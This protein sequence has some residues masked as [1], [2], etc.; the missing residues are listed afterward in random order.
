[1]KGLGEGFL[2][3]SFDVLAKQTFQDFDVVI[4]DHSLDDGIENLCK[5][6]AD[7]LT[8]HYYRNAEH[9]G[10]SS[11]N[12][13][14]AIRQAR[15]TLIK[16][17]FQDDFLFHEKSLEEI[18]GAFDVGKDHW[19]VSACIHTKDG[20]HFFRPFYPRYNKMIHLGNNTISS[21]SVLTIKNDH[22]L[23]FDE[24]LIWLMDVD[25]YRRCYDSFGEPKILNEINVV[26]RMGQHQV[27]NTVANK[28]I[29]KKEFSY[30]L[31]KYEKG[32][33]FWYYKTIDFI[34]NLI[35]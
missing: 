7:V 18:V 31:G 27:S 17:L 32:L 10:S 21:P 1:M 5:R 19:L 3:Q 28:I 25:Y 30:E 16:I 22:P 11:S 8:I 34:K 13:N 6:Y 26:N 35:K 15:G 14:N 29:R 33:S 2:R 9:R 23:L 20:A 12:I 24:A 4:S